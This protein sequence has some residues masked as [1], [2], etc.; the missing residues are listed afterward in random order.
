MKRLVLS[1][2]FAVLLSGMALQA[3]TTQQP[4][5][6][7]DAQQPAGRHM[8]GHHRAH[9]PHLMAQKM[10]QR[11]NLSADQ[12]AKLEPILATRQQK[13]SALMADTSLTPEARREQFRAIH[14]ES[15]QQLDALLTPEQREQ[16]KSMHR[17]HGPR[18]QWQGHP[19]GQQPPAG[20]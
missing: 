20:L 11:L 4:A 17:G 15:K 2:A 18:G 9:D 13:V 14:Q 12:T 7:P 19:D 5:A 16:L 6:P 10:G 3:Q 8:H 1:T